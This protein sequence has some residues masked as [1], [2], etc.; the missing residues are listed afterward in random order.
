MPKRNVIDKNP[1]AP[2]PK[3]FDVTEDGRAQ[4]GTVPPADTEFFDDVVELV[5]EDDVEDE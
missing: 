1:P 5:D 2:A 4:W 3:E